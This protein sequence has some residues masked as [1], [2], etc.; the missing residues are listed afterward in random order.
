MIS[1]VSIMS[2]WLLEHNRQELV[3]HNRLNLEIALNTTHER[4]N[5]WVEQH[6]IY[7]EQLTHY[8]DL[9]SM[10]ERL[11]KVPLIAD[12]LASSTELAELRDFF[13]DKKRSFGDKGFFIINPDYIS[14]GSMRDAN[15]AKFNLIAEQRPAL[16]ER[17]L[18]GEAQFIPPI[19]SDVK[20][21]NAFEKRKTITMFFAAPIRNRSGKVIAIL[22]QRLD[23][24]TGFSKLFDVGRIGETG[25]S[26]AF[27]R[28]GMLLSESHF[29][30]HL[31]SIGLLAAD[32][33]SSLS[34]SVRDPGGDML[35]GYKPETERSQQPL[36]SMAASAVRGESGMNITGYRDYRGIPVMGAWLWDQKLDMGMTTEID[37]NEA[38]SPYY[39]TRGSIIGILTLTLLLSAGAI[40]FT[41]FTGER[42]SRILRRSNKALEHE[43]EEREKSEIKLRDNEK[44]VSS[45]LD[46]VAEGIITM[47]DQGVIESF[48]PAAEA[49]FGY[50]ASEAI[51]QPLDIIC[52]EGMRH[53][54]YIADYMITG[55]SDVIG[56][57]R[58][59]EGRRRDGSLFPVAVAVN[60]V[61]VNGEV[62]FIGALHDVTERKRSED[63][64][65]RSYEEMES[66]V[67][68]RTKELLTAKDA[69]ESAN[70]A[71]GAF[72]SNMSHELRTPLNVILGFTD[73]L[74]RDAGLPKT[75]KSTLMTIHK[76]GD[77]LLGII[78][79]VL[80]VSKIEA[81]QAK[82]E[83][84]PF[85][86]NVMIQSI[87]E[88]FMVQVR[89]KG[90]SFEVEQD[91]DFPRYITGD[92]PK[93]RQ[94]LINLIS[95]AIKATDQGGII[96]RL[97]IR[98]NHTEHLL[99]EVEDSGSGI[100]LDD[101][102]K[103][104]E[105][106]T[107][108]GAQAKQQGTG[109]G[110]PISRQFVELMGGEISFSSDVG[111]GSTF[112][113]DVP[114]QLAQPNEIP[115]VTKVH[116][117]VTGLASGEPTTRVL[118]VEDHEASRQV[119]G[120][121]LEIV[122]LEIAYAENGAEAVELFSSWN[123]H[124]IWM[125]RRMPVMDGIEAVLRIRALPGG[126]SVRIA[127]VTASSLEEEDGELMAA[128]FDE[129]VHKPYRHEQI[130]GCM[131]DLLGLQFVSD[132]EEAE[133]TQLPELSEKGFAAVPEPLRLELKQALLILDGE[134][135]LRAI[136]AIAK[137]DPE[138][139]SALRGRAQ[140][141]DYKPI[142][143]LL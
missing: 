36:T 22:T 65:N 80:D 86:L 88:M 132:Q 114:V 123:P 66:L 134:R 49:M 143:A 102:E 54:K 111:Q 9:L 46:T 128:G 135:I 141:Y 125:D 142:L 127:A 3:K 18:Q 75:Y 6:K 91:S 136:N 105:D 15:L 52:P 38:L 37:V 42:A 118:V 122:G 100:P 73:I 110:L 26:Y 85:D 50:E 126:K 101:Q 112:R 109:L 31:R 93:L 32:E 16:L 55:H 30:A 133:E 58:E 89:D 34:V 69:A 19:Y 29:N 90:L 130:F 83:L 60:K 95:N 99:I 82:L 70:R 4:L 20:L 116:G 76:S 64:L 12:R 131:E 104:F 119:L 5:I 10:T 2:W 124:F 53:D 72:L 79:N 14:I 67:E 129:V 87:T 94:V 40:L 48:N 41:L 113:I 103:V 33:Q 120:N 28:E 96:L 106:F 45:I 84:A 39:L 117:R 11:L 24:L 51:G 25:E 13:G 35:T 121:L 81:G 44:R 97:M 8:P 108:I 61:I 98:E 92:E 57:G 47:D 77:H 59:V 62:K 7:L 115:E 56:K 74:R 17:V 138:L 23:P 63:A 27:S 140:N 21:N 1:I 78:N 137:T 107:Q 43:I 71:K 68:E 139:G